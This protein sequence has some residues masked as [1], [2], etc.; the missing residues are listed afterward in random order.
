MKEAKKRK[1]MHDKPLKALVH[2]PVE[3]VLEVYLLGCDNLQLKKDK[4]IKAMD[5]AIKLSKATP[6]KKASYTFDSGSS[7]SGFSIV[8]ILSESHAA[9]HS[10]PEHA[11]ISMQISTCGNKAHPFL[12][13]GHLLEA[14]NPAAGNISYSKVG[15][16]IIHESRFPKKLKTLVRRYAKQFDRDT[17]TF[18]GY[19]YE[20]GD[21]SVFFWNP[22]RLSEDELRKHFNLTKK[23]F[24]KYVSL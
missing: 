19:E 5:K 8:Y 2:N 24:G 17:F 13:V 15:M 6:L 16:D 21:Y 23:Q 20:P 12:S 7:V 22:K 4:I 10:S 18:R 11:Y 14:F 1:E 9:A 3:K